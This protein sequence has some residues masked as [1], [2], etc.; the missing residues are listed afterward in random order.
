[1]KTW[2]KNL[3]N[4]QMARGQSQSVALHL[5]DCF[6]SQLCVA[7]KSIAYKKSVY[8]SDF[9]AREMKILVY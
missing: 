9:S 5:L 2:M 3:N 8:I 6:Q 4:F 1:M 7:Y